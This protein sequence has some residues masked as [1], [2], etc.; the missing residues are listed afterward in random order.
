M[1]YFYRLLFFVPMFIIF[2][3]ALLEKLVF[4]TCWFPDIQRVDSGMVWMMDK[5][6]VHA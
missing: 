3:I 2:N 1:K 5:A 4:N 6:D